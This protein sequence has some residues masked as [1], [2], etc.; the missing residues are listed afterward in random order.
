[1][2]PERNH[3]FLFSFFLF[4]PIATMIAKWEIDATPK[5]MQITSGYVIETYT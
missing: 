4:I 3:K 5:G 1:M 2:I